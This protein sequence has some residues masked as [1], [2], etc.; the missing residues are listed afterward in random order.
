MT[1]RSQLQLFGPAGTITIVAA[2]RT[3]AMSKPLV[4]AALFLATLG[5]LDPHAEAI[6]PNVR[7]VDHDAPGP[8]QNGTSWATAFLYL[9]DAILAMNPPVNE[10]WVAAGTYYPDEC[11]S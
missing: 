4:I 6:P 5:S 9:A 2:T 3:P 8:D 11:M 1:R 7:V 10:I